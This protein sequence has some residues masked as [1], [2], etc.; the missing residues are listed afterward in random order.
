M[1]CARQWALSQQRLLLPR[2]WVWGP[3]GG[4][5]TAWPGGFIGQKGQTHPWEHL[6]LMF[7]CAGPPLQPQGTLICFPPNRYRSIDLGGTW[8][9]HREAL[10]CPGDVPEN[11]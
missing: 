3:E 1:L 4:Y 11:S 10:I 8:E 7:P 2:S 6:Q 5:D 9:R